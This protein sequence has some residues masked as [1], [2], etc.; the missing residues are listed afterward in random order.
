MYLCTLN[1][2]IKFLLDGTSNMAARRPSWKYITPEL[3]AEFSTGLFDR[4]QRPPYALNIIRVEWDGNLQ[5]GNKVSNFLNHVIRDRHSCALLRHPTSHDIS[6]LMI[7]EATETEKNLGQDKFT[8]PLANFT[9][10]T[11]ARN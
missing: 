11:F 3:M 7:C 6:N 10:S 2:S 8:K 9:T 4:E 5:S 1:I